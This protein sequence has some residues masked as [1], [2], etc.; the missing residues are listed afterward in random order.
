MKKLNEL[1]ECKYDIDIKGIKINSKEVKEGDLFIC[2]KGVTADR[3]DYVDDA[4]EHGAVA[5][6][7]SK[8]VN[9]SV[10]VI[11]VENTNEELPK[12]CSRFYDHPEDKIRIFSVTGTDGKTS[13]LL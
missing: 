6:V 7:A 8:P 1:Y 4:I 10:P 11:M 12:L 5:I 3:H 13:V 9:V 2:T